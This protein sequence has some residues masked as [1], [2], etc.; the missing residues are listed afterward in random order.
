MEEAN[1]ASSEE[2]LGEVLFRNRIV[3][4]TFPEQRVRIE[5]AVDLR[6]GV[7]HRVVALMSSFPVGWSP[8]T[9]RKRG[10][11]GP[12]DPDLWDVAPFASEEPRGDE[13]EIHLGWCG[14]SVRLDVGPHETVGAVLD[15][16]AVVEVDKSDVE[17][18][19]LALLVD[20]T[21]LLNDRCLAKYNGHVVV[22][23]RPSTRGGIDGLDNL[24]FF[25]PDDSDPFPTGAVE[26]FDAFIH[27]RHQRR[28][29]GPLPP[30]ASR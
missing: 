5:A 15:R 21:C 19:D 28:A 7:P 22:V 9:T 12:R 10:P 23:V 25:Q 1:E 26:K 20:G 18:K 29:T 27:R 13:V 17:A 14:R 2:R 6:R 4:G 11:Y 24:P 3:S 16:I 8:P 30:T